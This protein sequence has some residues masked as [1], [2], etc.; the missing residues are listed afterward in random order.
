MRARY[1]WAKRRRPSLPLTSIG[2]RSVMPSRFSRRSASR[3]GLLSKANPPKGES[4]DVAETAQRVHGQCLGPSSGRRVREGRRTRLDAVPAAPP[5]GRRTPRA[6]LP[7]A[8]ARRAGAQPRLDVRTLSQRC[9]W[10]VRGR[11]RRSCGAVKKTVNS[12][13]R[14]SAGVCCFLFVICFTD[15][16]IPADT[17]TGESPRRPP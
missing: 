12:N 17:K 14:P 6:I 5:E 8:R 9:R 13:P 15:S 3:G 4:E 1:H 2:T 11:S 16:T 10:E 7:R